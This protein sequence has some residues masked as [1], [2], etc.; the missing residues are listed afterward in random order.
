[1]TQQV[2]HQSVMQN[3]QT[4]W[5]HSLINWRT[6][7]ERRSVRMW[8]KESQTET[9]S[10]GKRRG[11]SARGLLPDLYNSFI[12]EAGQSE[13]RAKACVKRNTHRGNF[14]HLHI[15]KTDWVMKK[16]LFPPALISTSCSMWGRGL[17]IMCNEEHHAKR[18]TMAIP[19]YYISIKLQYTAMF[20]KTH[21]INE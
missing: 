1:M 8:K 7:P 3:K 20:S 5:W 15:S 13:S 2:R 9:Q 6:G 21:W 12:I 14:M 11:Q 18:F 16:G 10:E 19:L 4:R 17:C